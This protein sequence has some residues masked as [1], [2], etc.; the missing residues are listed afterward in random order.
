[1]TTGTQRIAQTARHA[2]QPSRPSTSWTE[3]VAAAWASLRPHQWT[4][5]VLVLAAVAFSQ[6]LGHLESVILSLVAFGVFCMASSAVYLM[7]DLHD[8]PQDRR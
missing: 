6:S 5:N 1:M 2:V 8:L 3:T 7:N 4:K